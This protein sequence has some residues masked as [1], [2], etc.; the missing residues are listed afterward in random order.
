M[1]YVPFVVLLQSI[2]NIY[3]YHFLCGEIEQHTNQCFFLL[4]FTNK[5]L[6]FIHSMA[7]KTITKTITRLYKYIQ[8]GLV[9]GL[10]KQCEIDASSACVF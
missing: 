6:F 1:L 9:H 10:Y 8:K 3:R 5:L 2:Q 4:N 7:H